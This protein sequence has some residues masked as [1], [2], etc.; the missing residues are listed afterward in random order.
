MS[1]RNNKPLEAQRAFARMQHYGLQPDI[2]TLTALMDVVGRHGDVEE[3]YRVY[4]AMLGS[5]N[6]LPNVVTYCT[7]LRLTSKHVSAADGGAERVL[8]LVHDARRLALRPGGAQVSDTDGIVDSSIY[9]AALAAS[10]RYVDRGLLETVLRMMRP[11]DTVGPFPPLTYE[12]LC[13]FTIRHVE[14][15]GGTYAGDDLLLSM[16]QNGI[17][18]TE[19]IDEIKLH[20]LNRQAR[21]TDNSIKSR[22]ADSAL[23]QERLLHG[24]G[25]GTVRKSSVGFV[26]NMSYLGPK[27]PVSLRTTVL[28]HDLTR[29]AQRLLS[30]RED[31]GGEVGGTSS[32]AGVVNTGTLA[33]CETDF[34]TIIH[35][36][37]KR[38]WFEQ[39]D[40]VLTFMRQLCTEGI[41]SAGVPAAPA[42]ALSMLTVEAALESYFAGGLANF[43]WDLFDDVCA[44]VESSSPRNAAM[45]IPSREE[46]MDFS[47]RF[48]TLV[49]SGFIGCMNYE[50]AARS[51]FRFRHDSKTGPSKELV[52]GMIRAAGRT[53]ISIQAALSMLAELLLTRHAAPSQA[54]ILWPEC[55]PDV[56]LWRTAKVFPGVP[57]R[58]D[59]NKQWDYG[60]SMSGRA[61]SPLLAWTDVEDCLQTLLRSCSL[62]SGG[63]ML[64]NLIEF[65]IGL[66]SH[67]TDCSAERDNDNYY[68][69]RPCDAQ[70]SYL[71]ALPV[72]QAVYEKCMDCLS[73]V[74][75]GIVLRWDSQYMTTLLMSA[76]SQAAEAGYVCQA[77]YV[78]QY[79]ALLPPISCLYSQALDALGHSWA[80]DKKTA[81]VFETKKGEGSLPFRSFV[82]IGIL[83]FLDVRAPFLQLVVDMLSSDPECG[84]RMYVRS[85]EWVNQVANAFSFVDPQDGNTGSRDP[86]LLCILTGLEQALQSWR[87][88]QTEREHSSNC[89]ALGMPRRYELPSMLFLQHCYA[90]FANIKTKCGKECL[91]QD[92]SSALKKHFSSFDALW[93][94][95]CVFLTELHLVGTKADEKSV[96]RFF[97][98]FLDLLTAELYDMGKS[99]IGVLASTVFPEDS[100]GTGSKA[101]N[102]KNFSV[103]IYRFTGANP[104]MLPTL[105]SLSLVEMVRNV[106]DCGRG[107]FDYLKTAQKCLSVMSYDEFCRDI[108]EYLSRDIYGGLEKHLKVSSTL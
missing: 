35:Q 59:F 87:G 45:N 24:I 40:L 42:L 70:E 52:L 97:A 5:E 25:Y 82:L 11:S 6:T 64:M 28:N 4:R 71:W 61:M 76:C 7:L 49:I 55:G 13:K 103:I 3:A 58:V 65:L 78:M 20:I 60:S 69:E 100:V 90:R 17:L 31:A 30:D 77:I 73:D 83:K 91:E 23:A 1:Q 101:K 34:V 2:F 43:A 93:K 66:R 21:G 75:N 95:T 46:L 86:L 62:L 104:S 18:S 99:T 84:L 98:F 32:T 105:L 92:I 36:C 68:F 9:N 96:V 48:P 63:D 19:D 33:L 41:P 106:I 29:L 85:E 107:P 44:H 57:I 22:P 38:K 80:P 14:E 26:E 89:P 27:S 102:R 10:V 79:R 12:I 94:F 54:Q 53:K 47:H 37:R 108:A 50:Y 56:S 51:F 15:C 39:V 16:H 81:V 8:G 72:D 67:S 88:P 74:L